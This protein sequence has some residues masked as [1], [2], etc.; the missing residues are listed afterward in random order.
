MPMVKLSRILAYVATAIGIASLA[1][2]FITESLVVGNDALL[3]QT[4]VRS[5]PVETRG[6]TFYLTEAEAFLFEASRMT[7]PL[8][9]F[10]VL[11]F[12]WLHNRLAKAMPLQGRVED[13]RDT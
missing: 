10:V 3:E 1:A 11:F 13:V 2:A 9:V 7:F 6:A 4:A 8:S 5:V 12:V